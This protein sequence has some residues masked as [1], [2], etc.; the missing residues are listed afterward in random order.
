MDTGYIIKQVRGV[1]SQQAYTEDGLDLY[2][3]Y[4]VQIE[5]NLTVEPNICL[6]AC[7]AMCE[8]IFK[9]ILKHGKIA[10]EYQQILTDSSTNVIQLYR[11]ACRALDDL[12]VLEKEIAES[13]NKFFHTVNEVRNSV[14]LISHGKDLRDNQDLAPSTINATVFIALTYL[15][16]I[17]ESYGHLISFQ[18]VEYEANDQFNEYLDSEYTLPGVVYSRALFDQDKIAYEEQLDEY[19]ASE[20]LEEA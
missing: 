9:H 1:L 18:E 16:F 4:L 2:E 15:I 20:D 5:S 17:L 13:G 19:R 12:G 11:Y 8:G 7:K 14:G 10:V 3:R 6:E